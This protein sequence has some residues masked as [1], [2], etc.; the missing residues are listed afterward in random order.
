MNLFNINE[1]INLLVNTLSNVYLWGAIIATIT[2]I[3]LGWLFVKIKVFKSSWKDILISIVMNI[4]FPALILKSFM[5]TTDHNNFEIHAITLSLSI[6]F[7]FIGGLLYL[8]WSRILLPKIYLKFN[9]IE[10]SN[11]V[12]IKKA[13]KNLNFWMMC[14]YG[15]TVFFGTPIINAL[16]GDDGLVIQAIW[17]IPFIV[18]LTSFCQFQYLDIKFKK[19]NKKQII[20]SFFSPI[21]VCSIVGLIIWITQLIPGSNLNLNE[22]VYYD[23]NKTWGALNDGNQ[24]WWFDLQFTAPWIY[25]TIDILQFLTSPLIWISIGM[26]VATYKLKNIF[27]DKNA[28]LYTIVKMIFIPFFI[29]LITSSFYLLSK[30]LMH[31]NNSYILSQNVI[32]ITILMSTPPATVCL[33]YAIKTN[34]AI[35]FASNSSIISTL[36]TPIMIPIWIVIAQLY[37]NSINL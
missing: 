20:K 3:F 27:N 14:L 30:Q 10:I 33:A 34:K 26:T 8:L 22:I 5:I 2:I 15:S 25:K 21:T 17:N 6:F 24:I 23:P 37:C 16:Y 11:K 28:W 18:G 31:N 4:C 35:N 12:Y 7:Y 32:V 19:E 36:F 13:N 29:M 9:N 1:P